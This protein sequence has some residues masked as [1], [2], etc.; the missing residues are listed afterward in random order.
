MFIC[1]FVGITEDA[2]SVLF[3]GRG[4]Q[5]LD[6]DDLT[7]K[8]IVRPRDKPDSGSPCTVTLMA[9]SAQ[10]KAE[11]TSDISQVGVGIKQM[12]TNR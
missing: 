9:P 6:L 4:S 10:E 12:F 2:E 7:F 8:L 1:L 5:E 3:G 11:W